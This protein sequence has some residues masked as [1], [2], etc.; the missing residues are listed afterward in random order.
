MKL[1]TK[2]ILY[3]L[4]VCIPLMVVVAAITLFLIKR[5]VNENL[6]ELMWD[7]A[8]RAKILI[9]SFKEPKNLVISLDSL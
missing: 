7:E 2:T 9:N 5:A 8:Q 1:I 4:L 3:Y 6:N